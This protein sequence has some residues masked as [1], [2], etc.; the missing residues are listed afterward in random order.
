MMRFCKPVAVFVGLLFAMASTLFAQPNPAN[1]ILS[2]VIVNDA[3]GEPLF[4]ATVQIGETGALSDIDGSYALSLP[5]GQYQAV[6]S[7]VAFQTYTIAVAIEAGK[8][9]ALNLRLKEQATLLQM[10]TVTSGKYEKPLGEVT[11]SLEVLRPNLIE[12]TGKTSLEGALQKVPGVTIIDGSANIRSGSGYSQGAGSRVLLLVDD[13]PILQA[14][15]G[16]PNWDDVPVES[17]EQVEVLKGAASSLYGS[18]ALNGIINVRTAYARSEPETKAAVFYTAYF[19]PKDERLNWWEEEG[20]TPYTAGASLSHRRKIGKVDVV[21]GGYYLNEESFRKDTY[22][23]YG[24]ANFNL[25][26]RVTDRL[27]YGLAGNFNAGESGSYFYW[28]TDTAAY[29]GNPTTLSER[30][31]LRYN[32]DPFL[33]YYDKAG[34]RH[35]V[36]GR[37]YS[38]DNDNDRNQS[39]ASQSYYGEYQYHRQ[40]AGPDVA[41]TAGVVG[42]ATSV[43]AELYGDTT[44]T[45]QNLATYVQLDKKFFDRL[46]AS[47]GFRYEYNVLNN[48]GFNNPQ[49][50]VAPSKDE[51]SRPVFRLGLNYQMGEA[52]YL[53]ASWGQGY[54]FP[55]VAE[56]FIFTDAGG[57]FVVPNPE[58]GSE[59]GWSAEVGIKQGFRLG[60]FEGFVDLAAY[61]M[62]FSDMIEFNYTI[63]AFQSINIGGTEI[64][65]LEATIAGQGQLGRI[66]L[67]LLAG[68]TYADP[69]FLAWDTTPLVGTDRTQ[70]QLNVQNSSNRDKNVLKYRFRHTFKLDAETNFN[71]FFFGIETFYTSRIEAVDFIFNIIVGGLKNFQDANPNGFWYHNLR[72]A[73]QFG[74]QDKNN[75]KVSLLLGNVANR[76]YT[77]RPAL[78]EAPRNLTLRVDATF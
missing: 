55:T 31:R 40:L 5:A 22:R 16:Y 38:V 9:T 28:L 35:R 63:G 29:I 75:Y 47:V 43:S 24:R 72:A 26:H 18:S 62:R 44:F 46:N 13:V 11:V 6:V 32:L 36:L 58:L 30:S 69:R 66:P 37:F 1:G 64:S 41:I 51:E 20:V 71:R 59:T 77:L 65:G 4:A 54:R 78:M 73:Y 33:T 2:G 61:Y 45:S 39:N 17:I 56:K 3:S 19:S 15:A 14:D 48:P 34:N 53:R 8:T 23:R 21:V 50:A 10:A 25:R 52:T 7:Y 27:S 76:A 67:R 70:G 12:S 42:L 74:G 60:S 57:F 68:Y 49:G